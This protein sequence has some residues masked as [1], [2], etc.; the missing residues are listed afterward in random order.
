LYS[1]YKDNLDKILEEAIDSSKIDEGIL[2]SM[3]DNGIIYPYTARYG[4]GYIEI[5]KTLIFS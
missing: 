1:S 3:T 2:H 5:N 4:S